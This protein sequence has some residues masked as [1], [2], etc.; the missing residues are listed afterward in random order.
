MYFQM[1]PMNL[2]N[3]SAEPVGRL[4]AW[5]PHK[6]QAETGDFLSDAAPEQ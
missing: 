3:L 2:L 5:L 4:H 6:L 1:Y